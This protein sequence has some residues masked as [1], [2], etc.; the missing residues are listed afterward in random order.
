MGIKYC[1][2]IEYTCFVEPQMF[3]YY[4]TMPYKI[5]LVLKSSNMTMFWAMLKWY[6]N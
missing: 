5:T 4:S 3:F 1:Y 6:L 2:H